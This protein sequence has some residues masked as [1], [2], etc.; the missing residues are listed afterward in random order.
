MVD[1]VVIFMEEIDFGK[2]V[3]VKSINVDVKELVKMMVDE[4]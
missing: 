1:V 4:Y 3:L 2:L